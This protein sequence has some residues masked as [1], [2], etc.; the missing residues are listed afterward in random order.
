MCD[1]LLDTWSQR[2]YGTL[3]NFSDAFRPPVVQNG[4]LIFVL[5]S[6]WF[7]FDPVAFTLDRTI[8]TGI[9]DSNGNRLARAAGRIFYIANSG[10]Q[11]Q[12][13]ERVAGGF[14]AHQQLGNFSVASAGS[15]GVFG[16]ISD[17]VILAYQDDG[18]G[19]RGIK[20]WRA[21]LTSVE[22]ATPLT[23][24]DISDPVVPS[25]GA[26]TWPTTP[27]NWRFQAGGVNFSGVQIDPVVDII[28]PNIG[29]DPASNLPSTTVYLGIL[30]G[31]GRQQEVLGFAGFSSTMVHLTTLPV[32]NVPF[33]IG[34]VFG[35]H[36]GGSETQIVTGQ[37]QVDEV[38]LVSETELEIRYRIY[39]GGGP[40]EDVK[41]FY[42]DRKTLSEAH[43]VPR[44][45]ATLAGPA[46]GG[47]THLTRW[48]VTAALLDLSIF[49]KIA[50]A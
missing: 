33:N 1:V 28:A 26:P 43:N 15:I 45:E 22:Q 37:I 32:G 42:N 5:A 2:T 36:G 19:S 31:W 12:I 11:L 9:T 20:C 7:E 17:L 13:F 35:G 41:L 23:I 14:V 27:L 4:K 29:G 25:V 30:A 44:V 39:A 48:D 3:Q 18:A 49:S 40:S 50:S 8:I 21:T 46:T 34:N 24:T 10:G 47:G 16:H 6:T 38:V